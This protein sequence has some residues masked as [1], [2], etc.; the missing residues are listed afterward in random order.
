MSGVYASEPSFE[1]ATSVKACLN[2]VNINSSLMVLTTH[3]YTQLS[4]NVKK[5]ENILKKMDNHKTL[6]RHKFWFSGMSFKSPIN[7]KCME[8]PQ[9]A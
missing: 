2:V 3:F 8:Y 4:R 5:E 1:L 9:I 7:I 6:N